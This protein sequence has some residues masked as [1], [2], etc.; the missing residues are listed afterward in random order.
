VEKISKIFSLI[1][2]L[3]FD[4]KT[5]LSNDEHINEPLATGLKQTTTQSTC[6]IR[7]QW[8]HKP[9]KVL[10]CWQF[11][12]YCSLLVKRLDTVKALV[13]FPEISFSAFT[14]PVATGRLWWAYPPQTKL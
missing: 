4:Q 12:Q 11:L 8:K 1:E 6:F 3:Q 14:H 7:R 9:L 13:I 5:S 2:P 10:Q